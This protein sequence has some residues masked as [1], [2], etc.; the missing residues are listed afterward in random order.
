MNIVIYFAI[1]LAIMVFT[2]IYS[3]RL[4][5]NR[6]QWKSID[7][8]NK[9]ENKWNIIGFLFMVLYLIVFIFALYW[10]IGTK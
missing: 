10:M 7:E 3:R 6:N 4:S 9:S 8:F 1:F 5:W 2:G